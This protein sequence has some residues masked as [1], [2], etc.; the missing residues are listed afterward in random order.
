[1]VNFLYWG[2][3]NL[4]AIDNSNV[5]HWGIQVEGKNN[6]VTVKNG[7]KVMYGGIRINGDNNHVVFDRCTGIVSLTIRG[8]NCDIRIG[9]DTSMESLYLICMEDNNAIRIGE[10]C[11]F[12]GDV[13]IWNSDTH[14]ITD[15]EG[16][17][18]NHILAP[19]TIGNHVWLGKHA[20]ILKGVSIGDNS[21]IGMSSVVTKDVPN[22]S[23]AAGNP[24]R[25]VKEGVNWKKG[26]ITEWLG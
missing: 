5:G 11:M 24:A 23:I 4:I 10:D 15:L 14:L 13:E 19:I 18:L 26:F 6:V 3:D 8:N 9:K 22:N 17:P 20:K 12:S 2:G 25:V 1:M 7:A 16:R 21:I